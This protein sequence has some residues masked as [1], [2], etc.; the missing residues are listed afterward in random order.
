MRKAHLQMLQRPLVRSRKRS[1]DRAG[2]Q[3]KSTGRLPSPRREEL[4]FQSSSESWIH[5]TGNVQSPEFSYHGQ[6]SSFAND[7]ERRAGDN[8]SRNSKKDVITGSVPRLIVR[9]VFGCSSEV[10]RGEW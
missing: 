3:S 2:G 4:L 9:Q 7:L 6:A 10:C 8:G 5:N 1:R